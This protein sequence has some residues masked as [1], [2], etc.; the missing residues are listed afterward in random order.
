MKQTLGKLIKNPYWIFLTTI[1][2]LK[3]LLK[4]LFMISFSQSKMTMSQAVAHT[5]WGT[6]I[7]L[8]TLTGLIYMVSRKAHTLQEK[9]TRMDKKEEELQTITDDM[10]I[11]FL[12]LNFR[13]ECS[14]G[15]NRQTWSPQAE[16]QLVENYLKTWNRKKSV[17]EFDKLMNI[18][19]P[20]LPNLASSFQEV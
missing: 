11:R 19:F 18:H 6:F 13:V 8:L 1:I 5:D 15:H 10:Y 2:P 4:N 3:D 12:R 20:Q 17:E 16:K 14:M 9:T 7:I